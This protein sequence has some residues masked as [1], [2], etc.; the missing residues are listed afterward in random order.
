MVL[1]AGYAHKGYRG[2]GRIVLT[3]TSAPTTFM[4]AMRTLNVKTLMAHILAHVTRVSLV[5]VAVAVISMNATPEVITA[6]TTLYAAK[7][8]DLTNVYVMMDSRMTVIYSM[9]G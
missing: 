7:I 5:M 6:I 3:L 4:L 2:D 1:N 9:I 8:L